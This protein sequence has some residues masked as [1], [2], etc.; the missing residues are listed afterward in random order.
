MLLFDTKKVI[1][2]TDR[3]VTMRVF[4]NFQ[5]IDKIITNLQRSNPPPPYSLIALRDNTATYK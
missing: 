3:Q 5:K 2:V 1:I 4:R